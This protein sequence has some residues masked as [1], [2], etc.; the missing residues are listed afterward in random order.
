MKYCANC[1]AELISESQRFCEK[2]GAPVSVEANSVNPS[3]ISAKSDLINCPACQVEVSKAAKS[4]P[5]CGHPFESRSLA[6]V[7]ELAQNLTVLF[8]L[9]VAISVA[10]MQPDWDTLLGF[11]GGRLIACIA[12]IG[13]AVWAYVRFSGSKE[14]AGEYLAIAVMA[15][16]LIALSPTVFG[17]WGWDGGGLDAITRIA[18]IV[19]SLL[20]IGKRKQFYS[21]LWSGS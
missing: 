3:N 7:K 12:V 13:V 19:A 6:I 2:C 1:G 10:L 9:E 14:P 15:S 18:V 4:C 21:R 5:K 16:S 11:D 20:Y 17:Y 8:I